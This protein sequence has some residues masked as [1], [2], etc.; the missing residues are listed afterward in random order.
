M[1]AKEFFYLVAEMRS[2]QT[3]YFKNHQPHVFRAARKLENL[4]DAEISRVRA[5]VN[6]QEESGT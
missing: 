5:I 1:N 3:A 2:A 6:A 4:V